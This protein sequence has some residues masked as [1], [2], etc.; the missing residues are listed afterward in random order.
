MIEINLYEQIRYLYAVEKLSKREIARRLG[1]S[2]NTVKRY[3]E[4]ENVPWERKRRQGKCPVTDPIRET[5]KEW[6]ESDKE[7]K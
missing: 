3:C 7:W 2:R 6:L 1:V 5:V 4:G